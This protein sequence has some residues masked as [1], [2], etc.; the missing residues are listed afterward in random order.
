MGA[1]RE[2]W[3]MGI[4]HAEP[5]LPAVESLLSVSYPLFYH[6]WV[7]DTAAFLYN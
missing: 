5:P 4:L 3:G 6:R 2:F 7:A 1:N